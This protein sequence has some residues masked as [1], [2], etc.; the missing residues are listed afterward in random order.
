[1]LH[2][3]LANIY[4]CSSGVVLLVAWL[5]ELLANIRVVV[6]CLLSGGFA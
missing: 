4:M 5:H 1:M 6:L 3:L 2:E